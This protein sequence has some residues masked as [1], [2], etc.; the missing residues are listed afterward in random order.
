[1]VSQSHS[2]MSWEGDFLGKVKVSWKWHGCPGMGVSCGGG[3]LERVVS[4]RTPR[5]GVWR[6]SEYVSICMY[7]SMF[8][9]SL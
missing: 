5:E 9:V 8:T 6:E 4:Y 2:L 3:V 1:M 7:M